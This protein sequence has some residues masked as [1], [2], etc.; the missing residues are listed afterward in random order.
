[1]T[2]YDIDNASHIVHTGRG[3]DSDLIWESMD[4][5]HPN[6]IMSPKIDPV[7]N[8]DVCSV[9][10]LCSKYHTTVKTVAKKIRN[11]ISLQDALLLK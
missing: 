9:N 6:N 3:L 8:T 2:Q 1:M 5:K 10:T 4:W 7:D 11:G